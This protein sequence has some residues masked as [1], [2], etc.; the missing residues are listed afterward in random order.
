[1]K[2]PL[3]FHVAVP[4]VWI[5]A[6]IPLY[7]QSAD[8]Y[9]LELVQPGDTGYGKT[10]FQGT[11]IETFDVEVLGVLKNVGPK[12]NLILVRLSGERLDKTGIFAGMSGSPVYIDEKMVGAV[13]YMWQFAKEPIAGVTPI[14]EMIEI[15]KEKPEVKLK[16]SPRREL[17]KIYQTT[18]LTLPQVL[19]ELAL[20]ASF[21]G[22]GAYGK[23]RPIGTPLSL[24][25]FSPR[26]LEPFLPHFEAM[27]LVPVPGI[28]SA[29]IENYQDS[30]LQAGSTVSV[31]LARGDM[32][33]S[34]S[35]TATLVSGSNVY[36]FGHPFLSIGYTDMPLNKAAVLT[37]IPGLDSGKKISATTEFVGSIKQ[38]RATGIFGVTGEQPKL[39][40]VR[41]RLRTSRNELKEFNYEVV[42]DSL[43]TPFLVAV[44]VQSGITSSERA[45]GGQTLQIRCRISVK[46]QPEILF[47]NSVSALAQTPTFAA[48]SVAS[49]VSFLLNSGFD[50]LVMENIDL[51]IHS[52]E[53]TREARLENVWQEKLEVRAGEDLN[54][55]VFLRKPNGE[56]L[57]E[58]YPVR[59]PDEVGEGPL[60]IMVGDGP[61]LARMDD[62]MEL[63]EFVPQS[64]H[65][66]IRAINNLKKN[67][68]LYIRLFRDQP[69]AI[70]K[71]EVLPD[72]PPSL[73]TLYG[74]E[75]TSG[76][77]KSL[78]KVIYAEYELP[79]THF[80]LSGRKVVRVKIKN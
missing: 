73:L 16:D 78:K 28:G 25:G 47:E 71:G 40:P 61:S 1:M 69:G 29:K 2:L 7:S 27:G 60:D 51:E 21:D 70:V 11:K 23:L 13:A 4:A 66:L 37:I 3:L 52:V 24:S 34:V 20:E 35:G 62:E 12:R 75:K 22:G 53:K 46:D 15:F 49:L 5:T 44:T 57:V 8:F 32:D 65:Q 55:T 18:Q 76:D 38:D 43:L 54:L 19:R 77:I 14:Y 26:A 48:G 10:V 59:I 64:L 79:A 45:V 50:D 39:I 80:V 6:L 41:L 72:L 17:R 31:Q 9:P 63:G 36:A 33:I 67:D 68:R 30:P 42:T 56:T 74:S 58:K